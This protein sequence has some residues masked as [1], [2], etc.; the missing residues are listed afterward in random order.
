M[1]LCHR[2]DDKC[3]VCGEFNEIIDQNEKWGGRLWAKNQM[4]A[5]KLVTMLCELQDLVLEDH[6]LLGATLGR[7]RRLSVSSLTMA[8]QLRHGKISIR[9]LQSLM[10]SQRTR[11]TS[12]YG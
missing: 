2:R 6:S 12:F 11:I 1:L 9:K 7:E 3:F 4:D 8:Y 5:F 10:V